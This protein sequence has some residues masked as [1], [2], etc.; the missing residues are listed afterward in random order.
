MST[1]ACQPAIEQIEKTG[2]ENKPDRGVKKIASRIRIRPLKKRA[3]KNFQGRGKAA[4]QISRRHRF[5]L[6][7]TLGTTRVE[8]KPRPMLPVNNAAI[9]RCAIGVH[10]KD[11]QEDSDPARSLL[12]NFVFIKLNNIRDRSVGRGH[13]KIWVCRRG[14]IRIAKKS[15]RAKNQQQKKQR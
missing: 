10:V 9:D 4:E 15:E 1:E 7:R 3:L 5:V 14:A 13:D 11:R 6:L 2:G 8:T 12:Q